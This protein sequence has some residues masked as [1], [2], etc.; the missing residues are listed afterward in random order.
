[1]FLF[2]QDQVLAITNIIMDELLG[3]DRAPR[4]FRA[5]FPE[6]VL[7]ESLAGQLWFGKTTFILLSTK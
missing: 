4:A 5:K 3:E 6:E 1:M 7:Q 2:A